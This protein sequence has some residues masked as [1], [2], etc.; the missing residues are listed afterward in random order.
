[1]LRDSWERLGEVCVVVLFRLEEMAKNTDYTSNDV[2]WVF[3][4]NEPLFG[5]KMAGCVAAFGLDLLD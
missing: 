2:D 1:M 5:P 3:F 4:F